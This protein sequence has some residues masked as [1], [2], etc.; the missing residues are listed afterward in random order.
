MKITEIK[1]GIRFS[2]KQLVDLSLII[3]HY[4]VEVCQVE[5]STKRG[6]FIEVRCKNNQIII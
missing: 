2:S 4:G 6:Y 5:Y 1:N 3:N